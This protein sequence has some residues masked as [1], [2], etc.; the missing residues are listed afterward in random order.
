MLVLL[1]LPYSCCCCAHHAHGKGIYDES[2]RNLFEL[3]LLPAALRL[4][5]DGTTMGMGCSRIRAHSKS[6][7]VWGAAFL[8]GAWATPGTQTVPQCA[9]PYI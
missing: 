6:L 5:L 3:L 8:S 1:L 7:A 9:V 4:A 2:T